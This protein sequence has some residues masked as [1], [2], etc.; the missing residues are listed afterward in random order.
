M[1]LTVENNKC[2]ILPEVIFLKKFSVGRLMATIFA[3]IIIILLM[4]IDNIIS[5][6]NDDNLVKGTV[7]QVENYSENSTQQIK[8]LIN[9]GELKGREFIV[10]NTLTLSNKMLELSSNDKV[11]L[12]V[13]E[14]EDGTMDLKTY[15]YVRQ[16][17]LMYLVIVFIILVLLVGGIK[18]IN[19]VVSVGFTIAVISLVLIPRLLK[20]ENPITWTII[21]SLII[22]VFSLI[23]Q[24][25]ISKKS[26]SSLVGTLGGI[27][28]AG[29]VTIFMSGSLNVTIN[30]EETVQLLR[31]S[32]NVN[33]N[34]QYLLFAAIVIGA[35]GANIDMSMSVASAMNEIKESNKMISKKE[36][37]KAGMN[38]GRDVIGTMTN[39]LV[40]AYV[41]STL[42]T[43]M[44]FF[45]Y[46]V[47]FTNI[48]NLHD[49]S[50]E[51]L[52]S[53][54]GSIGIILCVPLTVFTRVFI[55]KIKLNN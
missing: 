28:V 55:E 16:N 47:S 8:V 22:A 17:K 4:P 38:V 11:I 3:I 41:G 12:I 46:N 42:A 44:V 14:L 43:L 29:V 51:I 10:D 6:S 49:I 9:Q 18:G 37:I 13:S 33:Y 36:F 27:I 40:L 39:T 23:I 50:I 1:K 26:V 20:G 35:L 30:T 2:K 32:E 21:C 24:Q 54:S 25:G 48:I 34:F 5:S 52:R 45:G 15:Q 53:L 7:V 31:L 19:A